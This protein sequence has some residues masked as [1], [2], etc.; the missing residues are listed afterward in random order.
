ME[1]A[2][3]HIHSCYSD[4]YLSPEEIV[5][6]S[7]DKGIKYISITDHDSIAAQYITTR[8]IEEIT[9]IP[10]VEFSSNYNGAEIHILAYFIDIENEELKRFIDLLREKRK[11]R[12]EE[13]LNK[14]DKIHIKIDI[15]DLIV[16][17]NISLGR[18]NIA[19]EMVR[20]GYVKNIKEAF[21]KYLMKDRCAYVS[22]YKEDY[23]KI[24][25]II[26]DCG[27]I[28][29]IAHLGK[30]Y[31]KIYLEKVIL[32][33]KRYG[34]NGVEVYHPSHTV[35]ETNSLYNISKKHK[36]LIT[37]GSDFHGN[38]YGECFLG[39]HG[40]S[41]KLFSKII[42]YKQKAIMEEIK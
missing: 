11:K 3:L 17:E 4:G 2:D 29:V 16:K 13:I 34:L 1:F 7:I 31:P 28:S 26:K 6:Y 42:N 25:N 9:I 38:K 41:E 18:G 10:G 23:K 14:L 33:L 21:D 20:K 22:G 35:E 37:G 30:C 5:K 12:V 32:D 15:E 39:T 36:L 40:I 27:G 24:L 19:K 8:N